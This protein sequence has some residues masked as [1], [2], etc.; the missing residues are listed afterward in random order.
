MKYRKKKVKYAA[1]YR[2]NFCPVISSI[3]VISV[4]DHLPLC[5]VLVSLCSKGMFSCIVSVIVSYWYRAASPVAPERP[6]ALQCLCPVN[7][8]ISRG[9]WDMKIYFRGSPMEDRF[10]NTV[11]CMLQ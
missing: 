4:R 7:V 5:F 1:K 2:G 3:G 8:F 9:F 6:L 11:V 10:G